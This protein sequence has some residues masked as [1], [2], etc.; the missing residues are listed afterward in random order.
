VVEAL[1]R[2]G[3]IEFAVTNRGPGIAEEE[4]PTLFARF[5]RTQAARSSS[6][7]GLGLGLYITKELVHAHGGRVWAESTP[8]EQTTFR[9]ALPVDQKG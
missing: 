2:G 8:G 4:V 1:Q 3:D 6:V 7:P 5:F 9:F